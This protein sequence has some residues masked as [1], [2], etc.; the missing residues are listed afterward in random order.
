[1]KKGVLSFLLSMLLVVMSSNYVYANVLINEISVAPS[2]KYDWV[3]L[4]SPDIIDISGWKIGDDAGI[5]YTIESGQ[6]LEPNKYYVIS[7]YQRLNNDYDTVYL[8]NSSDVLIDSIPYGREGE[9]CV[10]SAEG[11]IA[12]IPDGGNFYDCVKISTKD[13]SN[14]SS[15]LDPCPTPTSTPTNTPTPTTK[16][17]NMLTFTPTLTLEPTNTPTKK[18]TSTLTPDVLAKES[19]NNVAE[20]IDLKE[21]KSEIDDENTD[22][23]T[24][25]NASIR[26]KIPLTAIIFVVSGIILIGVALYPFLKPHLRRYYLM[27]KRKGR[28]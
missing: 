27:I 17:T 13:A 11:S 7:K 16:P 9:V 19:K 2:D 5:F 1:M 28:R 8:Y 23:D 18:P 24:K 21:E 22:E 3:E 14:D 10:P 12:R 25:D 6:T 4:Y 15:E 26:R 20:R